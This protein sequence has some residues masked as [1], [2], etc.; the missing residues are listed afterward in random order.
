M[1]RDRAF[2]ALAV[3]ALLGFAVSYTMPFY[4]VYAK[5]ELGVR[6]EISGV[7]IWAM[8]IGGAL[9]S[10]LWGYLNDTRGPRAVL[11]G[12]GLLVMAT[13]LLA[14]LVPSALLAGASAAPALARALPYV[15]GLVFLSGG[16]TI[17]A[18][19][20][21]STTYL[22]ELCSHEDRP[23]YIAVFHLCTLPAALGGLIVGWL[24]SFLPFSVVFLLLAAC[25]AVA[26]TASLLMP[27][28]SMEAEP[29]GQAAP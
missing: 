4:V 8:T 1:L 21:G 13:P 29:R 9:A 24:L 22:F 28:V 3:A 6:E 16:S 20:M 23:R 17:G 11:R 14:L 5:Q 18:L 25:G 7:Y 10:I 12:A 26:L 15:F 27:Y 19:W 2:R